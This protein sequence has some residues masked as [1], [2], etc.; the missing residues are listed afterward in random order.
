MLNETSFQAHI[1]NLPTLTWIKDINFKYTAVSNRLVRLLGCIHE[2]ILCGFDD[3]TQPWA[4]FA[5]LYRDEDKQVLAGKSFAFLHPAKLFSGKD[6]VIV[7]RKYPFYN[8]NN[9]IQGI[10]GNV[11]IA[12]SPHLLKNIFELRNADFEIVSPNSL[13]SSRYKIGY[14]NFYSI[15]SKRESAC[16]FYLIRGKTAQEI[17]SRLYISKRTVEKHLENIKNKLNCNKKSEVIEKALESGLINF[18]PSTIF[19]S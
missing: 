4:Q 14:P 11:T 1:N 17:A 13:D 16:L 10:I 12:S 7:S 5:E 3:F 18:I 19:I 6:I 8:Q 15:L 9:E 2:N